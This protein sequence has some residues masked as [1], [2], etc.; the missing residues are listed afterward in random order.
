[1]ENNNKQAA[2]N[3]IDQS[4]NEEEKLREEV[5]GLKNGKLSEQLLDEL[6]KKH[7]LGSRQGNSSIP[8]DDE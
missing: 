8:N 7:A 4:M 2:E 6:E 3:N 5:S 1:M